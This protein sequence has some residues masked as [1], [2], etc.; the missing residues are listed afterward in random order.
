MVADFVGDHVGL[1]E[2]AGGG[3]F[4]LHLAEEGEV[5]I[6]PMVAGAV[7][8]ADRRGGEAAGRVHP[9]VEQD[10]LRLFVLDLAGGE[11]FAPGVLGIAEDRPD[12]FHLR[13]AAGGRASLRL[14][15]GR[16]LAGAA[17]LAGQGA[18][19]LHR[20]L[21]HQQADDHY[22]GDTAEPQATTADT[23]AAPAE[24]ATCAGLAAGIH[25]VVALSSFA[26]KH[27]GISFGKGNSVL[28]SAGRAASPIVTP[29][30]VRRKNAAPGG[31]TPLRANYMFGHR[32]AQP[33]S[34]PQQ[35]PASLG[36]FRAPTF[37]RGHHD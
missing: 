10:Q 30:Y 23:H 27:G 11:D 29:H 35:W 15:C 20:V 26:P 12:E 22:D 13:V 2:V 18:E 1:G 34:R 28:S 33:L 5:E 36:R 4:L 3:E 14:G 7:E 25:Y 19:D 6:D 21:A 31:S 24:T 17:H 8:R 37:I 9:A 32:K 16:R